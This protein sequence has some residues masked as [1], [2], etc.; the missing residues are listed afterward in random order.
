MSFP[1]IPPDTVKPSDPSA[2]AS[3]SL[4]TALLSI[5]GIW[6]V[7]MAVVVLIGVSG[8]EPFPVGWRLALLQGASVLGFVAMV[9]AGAVAIVLETRRRGR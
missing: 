9:V 1:E 6:V 2:Q 5:A 8:P 7:A 4:V 3:P